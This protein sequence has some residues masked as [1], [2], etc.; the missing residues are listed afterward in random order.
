[1]TFPTM[2]GVQ[3]EGLRAFQRG[4]RYEQNPYENGTKEFFNWARGFRRER[5]RVGVPNVALEAPEPQ[6]A[7]FPAT[8]GETIVGA[9]VDDVVNL[10]L[11]LRR[12]VLERQ[13][14]VHI[15]AFVREHPAIKP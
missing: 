8:G 10:V 2:P 5:D 13:G 1:M 3:D 12:L 4:R 15:A 9:R 7:L 14:S 6:P 11:T